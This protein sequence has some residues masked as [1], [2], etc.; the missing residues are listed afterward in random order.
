MNISKNVQMVLRLAAV[1][2]ASFAIVFLSILLTQSAYSTPARYVSVVEG[3]E[4]TLGPPPN[5]TNIPLDTTI[6]IDALATA[7][8]NDFRVAPEVPMAHVYSETTGPLNYVYTYYPAQL[9]KRATSYNVS[10]TISDVPV[11][12]SFTTTAEPFNPNISFLLATNVLWI[13]LSAAAS[14][15]AVVGFAVWFRKKRAK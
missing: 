7:T 1:F 14:A 10:V 6:T 8:L 13:A 15:T 11:S 5:S 2:S 12:W 4:I 3:M 9:L